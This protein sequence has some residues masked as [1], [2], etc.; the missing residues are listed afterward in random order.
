MSPQSR[1]QV[2]PKHRPPEPW[3]P[4]PQL[5][6]PHV[7]G[8][9]GHRDQLHD[10]IWRRGSL[11]GDQAKMRSLGWTLIPYVLVNWVNLEAGTPVVAQRKQIQP[12]T[13]RLWVRSQVSLRG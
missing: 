7:W 12:G 1:H 8:L 3:T 9:K 2:A 4:H 6:G 13:M 10:C 5:L 11:K